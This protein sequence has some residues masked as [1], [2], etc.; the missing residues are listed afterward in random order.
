MPRLRRN[1]RRLPL[2]TTPPQEFE[3]AREVE[4]TL[5]LG[6]PIHKHQDTPRIDKY[7]PAFF[8]KARILPTLPNPGY[9]YGWQAVAEL[10]RVW[11]RCGR[12]CN[13]KSGDFGYVIALVAE[14]ARVW[15]RCGRACNPKSGDF[16][17]AIALVAELARVW[18]TQD[19]RG[20]KSGDF[21]YGLES[22][23]LP[24]INPFVRRKEYVRQN[25]SQ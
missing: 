3:A 21:G 4:F 20:P 14:L 8:Q 12:A 18:R 24:R 5:S 9:S 2:P 7:K 16:G 19:S 10:A 11:L 1:S 22:G 17:Y 13:P 23:S 25:R 6:I 15:L